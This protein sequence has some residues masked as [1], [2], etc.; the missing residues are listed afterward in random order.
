MLKKTK[1]K[2][3]NIINKIRYK[4]NT[5][6]YEYKHGKIYLNQGDNFWQKYNFADDKPKANAC[7]PFALAMALSIIL[8]KYVSPLELMK[9]AEN[10]YYEPEGYYRPNGIYNPSGTSWKF[11]EAYSKTL[12]IKVVE[13]EPN[14][15]EFLKARKEN[16]LVIL[17]QTPRLDGYWVKDGGH[18][19][20]VIGEENIVGEEKK[21]IVLDSGSRKNTDKTH[22]L[23]EVFMPCKRMWIF[24]NQEK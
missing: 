13:M 7:G 8:K 23:H 9:F 16:K 5:N 19:I 12:G 24:E 1:E 2:I 21:Y 10:G 15:E 22:T 11:F 20:L 18:Y 4:L 6:E 14:E 3:L 17:S